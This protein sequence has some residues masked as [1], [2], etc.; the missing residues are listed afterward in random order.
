MYINRVRS[1]QI[2]YTTFKAIFILRKAPIQLLLYMKK[3]CGAVGLR[4]RANKVD[5]DQAPTPT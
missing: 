1:I 3:C 5:A 4:L 2:K